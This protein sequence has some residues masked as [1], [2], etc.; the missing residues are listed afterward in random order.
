MISNLFI[1]N[2]LYKLTLLME[3]LRETS[4]S[5]IN[6]VVFAKVQKSR[7]ANHLNAI[8]SPNTLNKFYRT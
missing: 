1:N 7:Y 4:R 6:D 8:K 5:I 2:L 3:A